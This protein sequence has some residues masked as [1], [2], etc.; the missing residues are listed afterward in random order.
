MRRWSVTI[1]YTTAA[2]AL[3]DASFT[4]ERDTATEAQE[5]CLRLLLRQPGREI[6]GTE[7]VEIEPEG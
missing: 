4:V 7:V 5:A 6:V 3:Q 1:I 2:G